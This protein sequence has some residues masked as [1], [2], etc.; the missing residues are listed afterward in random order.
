MAGRP[1]IW[2]GET[3]RRLVHEAKPHLDAGSSLDDVIRTL[4]TG[5]P[6]KNWSQETLCRKY[7]EAR[8]YH[9]ESPMAI[10]TKH[11]QLASSLQKWMLPT[12]ARQLANR[13]SVM[14]ARQRD[15]VQHAL[16]YVDRRRMW[17]RKRK[18]DFVRR[19]VDI[20]EAHPPHRWS[21][22]K[23]GSDKTEKMVLAAVRK[24]LET[25]DDIVADTGLNPITVQNYLVS[26]FGSGE[27]ERIGFGHYA[28]P[29]QGLARHM[30]PGKAI[31][32]ALSDNGLATPAELRARTGLSKAQVAGALHVLKKRGKV[33]LTEYGKYALLGTAAA[34][35]YAKDAIDRAMA[36]GLQTVPEFM[37]FTG[38]NR[39]E[40]WAALRRKKAKG[41]VIEAYLVYPG[42]RGRLAAFAPSAHT[43]RN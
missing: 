19:E 31:L 11:D 42:R 1:S 24:G 12:E 32:K 5:P 27:I 15:H 34:H 39:G 6:W 25:K 8:R 28:A 33:V 30:P 37:E 26:L 43:G 18:A 4:R 21:R 16:D 22:L 13:V 3:G 14:D 10:A 7:R 9:G 23:E 40:I 2:A 38:K 35:V 20:V 41:E 17:N 29:E 36:S